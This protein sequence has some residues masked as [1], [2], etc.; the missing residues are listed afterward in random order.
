MCRA[1]EI[2]KYKSITK[3]KK[4]KHDKIVPLVKAKLNRTEVL[5]SQA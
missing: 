4:T 5:M 2:K 1:A 3:K